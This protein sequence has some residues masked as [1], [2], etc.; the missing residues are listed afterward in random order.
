M[1]EILGVLGG[2]PASDRED[3]PL[4]RLGDIGRLP[5]AGALPSTLGR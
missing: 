1:G 5:I 2:D 3:Q 4:D